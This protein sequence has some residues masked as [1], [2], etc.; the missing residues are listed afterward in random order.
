MDEAEQTYQEIVRADPND[1]EAWCFL[2]LLS[3]ARLKKA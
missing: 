1:A 2:G 3:R